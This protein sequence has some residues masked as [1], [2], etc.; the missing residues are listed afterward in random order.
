MFVALRN[1]ATV[2]LLALALFP[3]HA[4]AAGGGRRSAFA[5]VITGRITDKETGQPVV[6]AQIA[7]AGSTRVGAIS[8]NSGNFT[9][10][11]VSAGQAT[12]R[13]TRIGYQPLEQVVT[14]P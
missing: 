8:D 5:A 7:V 2:A 10:R 11:G 9:L 6:A 1:G 14:V 4:A 12:L 3:P 13:A